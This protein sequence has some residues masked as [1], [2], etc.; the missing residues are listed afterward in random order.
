MGQKKATGPV[1]AFVAGE[2]RAQKARRGWT[3]DDLEER[4]GIPRT[5]IDRIL[6]GQSAI[7]VE[8]LIPLCIGMDLDAGELLNQARTA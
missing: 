5:T 7:P 3:L 4:T 1:T 2:L 6:K 8:I